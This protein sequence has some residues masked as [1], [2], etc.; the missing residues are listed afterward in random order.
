[1]SKRGLWNELLS[2][3]GLKVW[4]RCLQWSWS[5]VEKRRRRK[6]VKE[7]GKDGGKG[8]GKGGTDGGR[9]EEGWMEKVK[10]RDGVGDR[11]AS[12]CSQNRSIDEF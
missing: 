12:K 7:K 6:R 8:G 4:T 10:D 2:G 1:M 11:K 9:R 5:S 3:V